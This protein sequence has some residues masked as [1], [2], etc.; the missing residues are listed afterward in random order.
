GVEPI[1]FLTVGTRQ[2]PPGRPP[3]MSPWNTFFDKPAS[4]PYQTHRTRLDLRRVRV[5]SEG[6]RASITLG[7]VTAG[8]FTGALVVTLYP[9]SRLVHVQ[10]VVSTDE[11]RRAILY[12]AG[13]AGQSPG[14]RQLAWMDTEGEIQRAEVTA[15]SKDRALAVRHRTVVAEGDAGSVACF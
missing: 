15:A 6:R 1:A 13:L 11:D 3:E 5:T 10:V 9:G 8:P 14:W 7:A 2:A 12:D 4:R